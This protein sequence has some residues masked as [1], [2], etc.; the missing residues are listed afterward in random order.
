MALF[1]KRCMN[2]LNYIWYCSKLLK[3]MQTFFIENQLSKIQFLYST[4]FNIP[5]SLTSP[6]YGRF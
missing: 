5:L 4:L 3:V 2:T 1:N 6:V